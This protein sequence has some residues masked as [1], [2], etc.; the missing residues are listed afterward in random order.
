MRYIK[1]FLIL[2]S[3][4]FCISLQEVFDNASGYGEYEKYIIL[5]SNTT[6][7][8][9]IGIFEGDVY[10]DC[11]GAIINLEEGNGIW[12]YADVEYPSSLD[13]EY[14][15]I[16]NGLYYGLS[17]GGMANG[18]VTNCNFINTDFGLKLFDVSDV[19]VTNSIFSNHSTY[20]IGIYGS[21]TTLETSYCLFWEN[22]E[23][24]CMENCPG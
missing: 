7:T 24:D 15:T 3:F 21:N 10:I 2:N 22:E 1:Y 13:I 12:V 9:G 17:F 18:N 20:G 19:S 14:C 5:D 16:T 11:Q 4:I 23:S 6:Y 8:G